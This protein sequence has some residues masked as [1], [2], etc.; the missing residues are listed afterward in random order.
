MTVDELEDRLNNEFSKVY[1]CVLISGDSGIGKTY[2]LKNK[3]LRES[4]YMYISLFGT[5]SI[6]AIKI[7]IY[8]KLNKI[9]DMIGKIK[10]VFQRVDGNSIGLGPIS[11]PITYWE[12]DIN[13]AISKNIKN[14]VLTVVIDDLERKSKE[15]NIE[16]ILGTIETISE[17]K[18]INV[19]L[20]ANENKIEGD[21]K[22]KF[23]NFKEKVIQKTYNV[24]KYSKDAPKE[25]A[26]YLLKNMELKANIDINTISNS[27]LEVFESHSVNNL[28]T[29]EKGI[30]FVKLIVQYIDLGELDIGEIKDIII[31]SLSVVVETI[32]GIYTKDEEKTKTESLKKEIIEDS[33][34]K[35]AHC[36]IKNYFK[37]Q[38][39]VSKK[40][41]IVNLLLDIYYDI[42]VQNNFA[43]LNKFYKDLHSIDETK[44]DIDLFYMSEKQLTEKINSFYN[45]YIVNT[46]KSLDVNN[47]F[48]KLNEIYTYAK[49]IGKENI[50]KDE[51]ILKAMDSYL[52]SLQLNEDIFYIL[53]RQIPHQILEEKML[54][55]NKELNKK[56]AEK[57]Y[58]KSIEEIVQ[59]IKAGDF[60]TESL[61]RL[62]TIYTEDHINFDKQKITNM[63]EENKYFIPDLNYEISDNIWRWSH[64]IWKK[65]RS[66]RQYRD[67]GFEKCVKKLLE[68]ST[69]IGKYRIE[70]LNRQYGINIEEL[71]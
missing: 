47:W 44:K 28:R 50:F 2:F 68:N 24:H 33:R 61:D 6:E 3:L 71:K 62:Y 58:S 10:K 52:E 17:I 12:T 1:K 30:N 56:I 49:V 67:N 13:K 40:G 23:L 11:L 26:E 70:L 51:E 69:I 22:K 43:K 41:N 18:N 31:A 4:K 34:N 20:V 54:E 9:C 45:N 36:I 7:E 29:L 53:D 21:D 38:Y 60:T 15:I 35:F 32:E 59:K 37:E 16:D 14:E 8:S 65:E 25:I 57:Y 63:L 27:I 39:F 55:Y 5:N 48:K 46:D 19:I 64:S 66:Y 42:D